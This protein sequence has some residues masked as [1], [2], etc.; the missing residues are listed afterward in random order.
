M[1]ILAARLR[2]DRHAIGGMAW[3]HVVDRLPPDTDP[4]MAVRP[5]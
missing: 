3:K 1:G 4:E 5:R 2:S